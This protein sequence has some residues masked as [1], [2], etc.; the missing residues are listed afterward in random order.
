MV[1]VLQDIWIVTE[2]GIVLFSRVYNPRVN[3][4]L[5]GALMTA[6]NSFATELAKG[7]LSSFELSS[8]RFTIYKDKGLLFVSN[9]NKKVKE[10]KVQEELKLIADK[11]ISKYSDNLDA[12][13]SDVSIFSEFGKE[14]EDSLEDTIK[15]FQ[16]A[17]W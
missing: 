9:S 12:W 6:L 4:Q 2:S 15:K 17:F 7:G 1:K 5:F 10:K 11:F 8:I 3:E 13:D 14:I 16:K